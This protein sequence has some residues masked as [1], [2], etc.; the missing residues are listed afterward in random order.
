MEKTPFV[1]CFSVS[2]NQ[3]PD[4]N[5]DEANWSEKILDHVGDFKSLEEVVSK[6]TE[7]LNLTESQIAS[8]WKSL[9]KAEEEAQQ[10]PPPPPPP[11]AADVSSK[12]TRKKMKKQASKLQTQ[13]QLLD[14]ADVE[15]IESMKKEI[16]TTMDLLKIVLQLHKVL[17][18]TRVGAGQVRLAAGNNISGKVKANIS[19]QV[20]ASAGNIISGQ[21]RAAAGNNISGQVRAG[22]I[23][24]EQAGL[25]KHV[26]N[27]WE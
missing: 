26:G 7:N 4:Y 12:S 27:R 22:N 1:L 3:I 17:F 6:L 16:S 14:P 24:S 2:R 18:P 19:G 10:V 11:S 15:A 8:I 13:S 25:R 20:R 23:I 9:I 5:P 21:V